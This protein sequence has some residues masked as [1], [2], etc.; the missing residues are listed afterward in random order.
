MKYDVEEVSPVERK[1]TVNVE[2]EEVNGA[3]AAAIA[4]Y[5][6][7]HEIKGFRK[8]KAPASVIE[9]KFRKQ[10]YGE[11]TTDLINYQINEIMA[12]LSIMPLSKID[13]DAKEFVR[14]EPFTYH[15]SF[16]TAPEIKLPDFSS[17]SVEEEKI[18]ISEDDVKEIENKILD[19][20]AKVSPIEDVRAPKDGEIVTVSFGTYDK[21]GNVVEGIKAESFDLT[22]GQAQALP[23]FE[24]LVKTLKTG[25]SGEKEVTFPEDFINTKIAGQTLTMKATVHAIKAKDVPE[26]NDEVAKGAGFDSVEKLREAIENSYLQQR[27]QL[28]RSNSQKKLLDGILADLNFE[29]PPS[30]LADRIDR[31]VQD[32]AYKLERQGK[33]L[34]SLGKTLEEL[35]KEQTEPAKE[36]VKAELLLLTVAKE[37]GLEVAPQEIDAAI[38]QMAVQSNQP[39]HNLKQ[40]YEENNLIV[41]LKDR[42]LADKAMELIYE[43][44]EIK[45][46]ALDKGKKVSAKKGAKK[47]AP[48]KKAAAK[49]APAKK[50]AAKKAPAKK[51]PAKKTKAD[52]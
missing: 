20:A 13:V 46:V 4:M 12:E 32:L 29:L 17:L 51:A 22:L 36:S 14:D 5:K 41:P 42:L 30:M 45:E 31:L 11:A 26:M 25:E 18:E 50:T 34:E 24:E 48:A 2:T 52:K 7:A 23:D 39:F 6:R 8:G 37:E 40:Y 16:E 28:A 49:K 1:I 38:N 3:L 19:N 27:K 10:I 33:S 21:D 43:S 9:S 35:R 47:K 44:A 15:I